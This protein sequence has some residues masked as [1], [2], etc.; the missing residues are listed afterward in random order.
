VPFAATPGHDA[1]CWWPESD[2][3]PATVIVSSPNDSDRAE[4]L[5]ETF[6]QFLAWALLREALSTDLPNQLDIDA[7][8]VAP[9][10]A[11]YVARLESFLAPEAPR[12]LRGLFENPPKSAIEDD[13]LITG[14]QY[15]EAL[16]Q[17]V[18]FGRRGETF[19]QYAE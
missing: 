11:D 10:L 14:E 15:D 13:A 16:K 1:Y 18:P 19:I 8:D 9:L 2:A 17:L 3:G 12:T 7:R 4:V 5:C 6:G